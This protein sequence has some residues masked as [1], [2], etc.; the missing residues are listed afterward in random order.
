MKVPFTWKVTGWFMIGWSAEFEIGDVKAL[1]YFGE[2]LAAYRDESG[3]LHVLEAHC[4]HLGAHIGHGGTVDV[5]LGSGSVISTS[6]DGAY[7][8]LAQSIGGGGGTGGPQLLPGAP[9]GIHRPSAGAGFHCA[10]SGS[11]GSTGSTRGGT[12]GGA[13][14]GVVVRRCHGGADCSPCGFSDAADAHPRPARPA[15][16]IRTRAAAVRPA[17]R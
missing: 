2:D 11:A 16:P 17:R 4:K 10:T 13:G 8:I 7:G 3:A 12:T 6:G 9:A 15:A 1:K 14:V 5:K